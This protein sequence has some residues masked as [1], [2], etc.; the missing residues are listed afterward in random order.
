LLYDLSPVTD[1][2]MELLTF[3]L[4]PATLQPDMSKRILVVDDERNIR[5]VLQR[6]L[7]ASGYQ[8]ITSPDGL[9]GLELARLKKPDLIILDLMLPK[10]DGNSVCRELRNDPACSK[11]PIIMLTGRTQE[12]DIQ[13][14]I[15]EGANLYIT[16]PFQ[17]EQLL[18]SIADLLLA[19]EREA[20]L[21][22]GT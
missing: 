12:R 10:L 13:Q 17:H 6:R 15:M 3:A 18:E 9:D 11:I 14:G 21:R 20:A 1:L 4:R 16:K 19:A 8:V 22:S 2:L 5:A 7:E